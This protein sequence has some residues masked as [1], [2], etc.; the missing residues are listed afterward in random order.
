VTSV[1]TVGALALLLGTCLLIT[2]ATSLLL[3]AGANRARRLIQST[4]LTPVGTW[5]PGTRRVA[6]TA[7]T[8]FGPAGPITGPVSGAECAWFTAQLQRMP[9]RSNDESPPP[10]DVLAEI[11]SP[12]P[13][14]LADDSGSVLIHPA[15]LT[16]RLNLDDPLITEVTVRL[17]SSSLPNPAPMLVTRKHL[18]AA[19]S[20]ETL[21]V[22]ETRLDGGK[23]A[24]AFGSA[25][26]LNG[27][28]ALKPTRRGTFSVLTT[29]DH[30]TVV[31]RR[32]TNAAD[33][34]SLAI[35]LGQAGLVITAAAAALL[36][37]IV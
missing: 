20:S 25:A 13:P 4:H 11:S 8:A 15:L 10:Y 30:S 31:A 3:K 1:V 16:D 29:D 24:Y 37:F 18:D 12:M 7:I 17:T 19:R 34:R 36:Y 28:V 14:A 2:S 22:V 9:S 26:R 32:H 6:T 21:R 33:A 23:H 5:R 35:V 27:S